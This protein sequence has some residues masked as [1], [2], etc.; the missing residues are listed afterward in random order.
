MKK[1][2][3]LN[4]VLELKAKHET[5]LNKLAIKFAKNNNP[6][7]KGDVIN[8]SHQKGM[9]EE[10]NFFIDLFGLPTCSFTC[11]ELKNDGTPKKGNKKITIYQKNIV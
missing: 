4:L 7:K 11:L 9:I 8:D 6:Y 5:E 3:Y 2:E 10:I 1:E